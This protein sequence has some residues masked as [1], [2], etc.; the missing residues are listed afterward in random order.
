VRGSYA[1]PLADTTQKWDTTDCTTIGEDASRVPKHLDG[2]RDLTSADGA[3]WQQGSAND[4]ENMT[5]RIAKD[6]F[7][8]LHANAANILIR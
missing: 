4:T 6:A 1:A 7:L 2:R 3:K 5:A 8:S